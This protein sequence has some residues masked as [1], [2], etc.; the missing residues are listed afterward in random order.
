MIFFENLKKYKNVIHGVLEKK[1]GQ[2]NPFSN[3]KA[4]ENILRALK[5]L[6]YGD[7][8]VDNLIFAEQ[9]HD[10][11]VYS[12]PSGLGG[13]I[14]LETDGLITEN[15]NQVLI[16][17]T[18]DC[19]PILIYDPDQKKVGA[20]HAGR[21]SIMKGIIETAVRNF[22]CNPSSLIVGIGPHIRK[23]CYCFEK[24]IKTL[25][26]APEIKKYVRENERKFYLDLTQIVVD[27][28]LE[29]GV[30][31]EN[32]E[33]CGICT[34]CEAERFYSAR[35][36]EKHPDIYQGEWIPC[37]GSFIGLLSDVEK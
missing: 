32:I 16:I 18:A 13:Y 22:N 37:F 31:R 35:K 34:F 2:V 1:D 27:K 8:N 24:D 23:C 6:G 28:L 14:K 7:A 3:S 36:R 15:P 25:I 10:S 9:V 19:V 11:K 4:E 5:K 21:K 33:D 26:S 17:R 12:C 20:V 30:K 29:S